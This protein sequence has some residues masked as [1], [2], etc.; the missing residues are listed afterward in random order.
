[1]VKI[2]QFLIPV[3]FVVVVLSG[4][5][6]VLFDET[7]DTETTSTKKSEEVMLEGSVRIENARLIIRGTTNLP[8]GSTILI[9]LKSFPE[10]VGNTEILEGKGQASKKFTEE[11]TA[12]VDEAGEFTKVIEKAQDSQQFQLEVWFRPNLQNKAVQDRY[13]QSGE[14]LAEVD[15]FT[16]YDLEEGNFRGIVKYAPIIN[17]YGGTWELAPSISH[18]RPMR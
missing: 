7:L 17:E 13:G 9:G 1:M 4:C 6:V 12:K 8:E 16:K 11:H 3:I 18:S 5:R 2:V 15:G 10:N 14:F